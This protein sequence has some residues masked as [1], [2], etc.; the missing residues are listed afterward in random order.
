MFLYC[1]LECVHTTHKIAFIN[2]YP[3]L[4][5]GNNTQVA[6]KPAVGGE[7]GGG[8]SSAGTAPAGPLEP[9]QNLK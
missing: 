7:E 6:N 4:T 1:H 5:S 8:S 3:Q 2:K 9:L